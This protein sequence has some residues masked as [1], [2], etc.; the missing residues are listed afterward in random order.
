MGT[1]NKEIKIALDIQAKIDKASSQIGAL[2]KQIDNFE[3]SKGL[4]GDFAKEFKNIE[5]ELAELQ[6]KTASGEI[7]L[8]DAKSAEKEID[9]IEKR[10]AFLLSKIGGDSFLEKGLKTDAQAMAA[11]ESLAKSYANGIKEAENQ[12]ARL[13]KKLDEAKQ[14]QKELAETQKEQKV[15]KASELEDQK[16][17]LALL[18]QQEKAA[19]KVRDDAEKALRTKVEESGGKY[20]MAEASQKGSPLR[21]TDAYRTFRDASAAYETA[22]AST[23]AQQ[24]NVGSMVTKEMQVAE[25]KAAQEAI[26]KATEALDNYRKTSLATAKED[27]FEKAKESLKSIAEFKDI[28]WEGLDIDISEIKSVEDLEKA[29]AKLRIEADKRA[30]DAIK[31]IETSAKE[32]GTGFKTMGDDVQV[33]KESLEGLDEQARQTEAFEARIKQFLGMAGAVEL[34]RRAL[35]QAFETTKELDAAMTEMAVVTDLEVGDYWKQLPDHTKRASEL[36]VA[37][38]SVYEAETLYYQQGLKTAEAQELANTTLRMAR[39]AGLDAAEATDK[40][41]AALRGFN[42]ELNEASAEKVADVYSELAAIT[43]ADVNEISSA[44]TK[45]ASIASSAGMEFETTAAFLS[46]IIETTRE[47]AETAGTAMKTVIARFSEVK[48]LQ[49]E[50]LLTGSDEEGEVIDVNKIQTALRSVGISMDEFFAGT[51]GL[52]SIFLKLAEKWDTLDVKTQRYIATT[53]AGSRQQSRFIAMMSD[54]ARTQELVTAANNSAGASQRQY[55]KT[56]ESL[57]SKLAQLKNAWDE[58][59]MGILQSDLVKFGVDALR[60]FLEIINKATSAFDGL[61]GTI[62]KVLTTIALFKLG[63]KIFDGIKKPMAGFFSSLVE[64]IYQ[65]GKK[66]GAAFAQGSH[67][68]GEEKKKELQGQAVEESEKPTPK[69]VQSWKEKMGQK[70]GQEEFAKTKAYKDLKKKGNLKTRKADLESK[71]A[72]LDLAKNVGTADEIAAAENAVKE[73]EQSIKDYTKAEKEAIEASNKG[74]QQVGKSL[75][76][77]GQTITAVGI[78]FSMFGGIL[79][80]L[81][82]EE[83]GEAFATIGTYI[84]FAGTALQILGPIITAVSSLAQKEGIKTAVAWGWVSLIA[85]GI[86]AIVAAVAFIF[87]TISDNNPDKKLEKAQKAAD[88]AAEGANKAAEAYDNLANSINSLDDQYKTLEEMTRGTEEWNKA[89]LSVNDSVVELIDKYPELA[90]FVEN[91]GGVLTLDVDSSE[92]QALMN[93][94][95]A[96]EIQAQGAAIGAKAQLSR[97]NAEYELDKMDNKIFEKFQTEGQSAAIWTAVGNL[98]AATAIGA[99]GG[100]AIG[101]GIGA[102]GA[103]VG[104]APGAVIG[105]I[106][107]GVAGLSAGIAGFQYTV[108]QVEKHNEQNRENVK[109]LAQAYAKG[110]TGETITEIANYIERNGIAVGDAAKEMANSLLT[111]AETMLEYGQT[112]NAVEEQEKAYYQAMA[113][114]A[115]QLLDLGSFTQQQMDTINTVVDEDLMK[116]Y[117]DNEKERLENQMDADA[118][119]FE[120]SK[121]DFAKMVYGE[122]AR[123]KGNK[124]VDET[125]E[126]LREFDNDESWINEMA[127]ANATKQAAEAMK[128]IPGAITNSIK[129]LEPE[130]QNLFEKAFE[131]RNLTNAELEKFST[132]LG[133]ITYKDEE[134]NTAKSWNELEQNIKDLWGSEEAYLKSLDADYSGIDAKWDQLTD[135]QKKAYGWNGDIN[136]K[137][138]LEKAK[139]AYEDTFTE[140]LEAQ[141]ASFDK[142]RASAE[143]LGITLASQL[144]SEAAQT[145]T[146]N[147]EEISLGAV[148][149]EVADL[150]NALNTLLTGMTAEQT[151]LVMA[152]ISAMDK[153]DVS[154]WDNLGKALADLDIMPNAEALEALAEAGKAAY[155][156]IIKI[157]FNT[158][159]NDIN[160]AYQTLEKTKESNRTYSEE[161]YKELVAYD[162]TLKKDFVQVGDKFLYVGGS[163]QE[164]TDAIEKN[165]V[166]KLTEANRQL[167]TRTEMAK[168]VEANAGNYGST[169]AMG[170]LDLMT[171]LIDMRDKF[172]QQNLN[173]EDLGIAGLSNTTDFSKVSEATLREWAGAI[174]SE[175]VKAGIYEDEY[176]RQTRDANILRFTHNEAS[177]NAQMAAGTGEYADQHK[178]ALIVQ[179][180]QSGGVSNEMI[181]A[182]KKATGD[183]AKDLGAK[184][185]DATNKI[186]ESNENRDAYKELIDRVT[187]AIKENR[188]KEIDKLADIN[189]SINDANKKLIDKIQ[190]QIDYQRQQDALAESEANLS[191]LYSQQIYLQ[192]D[193][194]GTNDLAILELQKEIYDAGKELEETYIDQAIQNLSDANEQAQEQRERQIS[195]LENQLS[196][197]KENGTLYQEATFMVNQSIESLKT[198]TLLE[199]TE[200]GALLTTVEGEQLNGLA[201]ADWVSQLT[202]MAVMAQ[203]YYAQQGVPIANVSGGSDNTNTSSPSVTTQDVKSQ[204]RSAALSSAKTAL[205]NSTGGGYLAQSEDTNSEL[206]KAY[207][208]YKTAGGTAKDL[209]TFAKEAMGDEDI[210]KH[211]FKVIGQTNTTGNNWNWKDLAAGR[212]DEG[213]V[214]IEGRS[215]T[216]IRMAAQGFNINAASVAAARKVPNNSVF[217][218]GEQGY[219]YHDGQAYIIQKMGK[220]LNVWGMAKELNDFNYSTLMTYKTGG[221]ADFTGP[222]WLDGTKSHPELVL[223]QRDTQ[224]FIQLKDILAD[225][226]SNPSDS[227]KPSGDNYYNIEISVE[228][229]K[230][231]YDVEQLANKIRS[232]LHDDAMYRNVNAI[233][234]IR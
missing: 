91:K 22:K 24:S 59:S 174:A 104:A 171:Y 151:E 207:G 175:G 145:W 105:A 192:A 170:S 89:V 119:A 53:A 189:D 228:E 32:A 181:E 94:Y 134:G 63:Q 62:T 109:E 28:D 176:K 26:D 60:T 4:A 15:V 16:A 131:G 156:A 54:Y 190:K 75:G 169:D 101:A 187:N 193:S 184:I 199:E 185:A 57:E 139:E 64:E 117:E 61:G 123:V 42:M 76:E 49:G 217:M 21:K 36:G 135:A 212:A 78:G 198:G 137:E 86:A 25:A 23:K 97:A 77:V 29:L 150:N 55:E 160:K 69:E 90:G 154:A 127:A 39:I 48:K 41:T 147:L 71:Q 11:L 186:V 1:Q 222:A 103:G 17:Q 149:G 210:H 143:K 87:K 232:M 155:N 58:F 47:S 83:A 220:E 8:I 218:Y 128:E 124:I 208:L 166:A 18:K 152:E 227:K 201:R 102:M 167:G 116:I 88:A 223:N 56:L 50:G 51:E 30:N 233:S 34:L 165:T 73:A 229:L 173:I 129:N 179:A 120:K 108:D 195:L 112:L 2:K 82:L 211:D 206:N 230:D 153:M 202:T 161:D 177:Y 13:N 33:A 125:G 70:F 121:E 146:S 216:E 110:E 182:Y 180:I 213:G 52:D 194:S 6:R 118:L 92:V 172:A 114:N 226:M 20:S 225:I 126:T 115:Q 72:D 67:D 224:N 144:S 168:I 99:G 7:N 205:S 204:Q 19:K 98:A 209:E 148:D 188:Q 214:T 38:H 157:D 31:E 162:S 80:Q 133:T 234:H 197:A 14:K 107:G 113:L 122:G 37:I 10:W 136:D 138:S 46:Q 140:I 159:A 164:L 68:G 96:N 40:M 130:L 74:W 231:D 191:N 66:S 85:I 95:K 219:I 93:T 142:A 3:L 65:Q 43:A 9:K 141:T 35:R 45:T 81:G 215:N 106:A 132:E 163:M 183:E 200:M 221:L 178:D 196:V 84:M 111:E 12:E 203:N 44:M 79:S 27:A 5:H 100:A 158:L